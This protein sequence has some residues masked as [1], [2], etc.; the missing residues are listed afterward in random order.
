MSRQVH[1]FLSGFGSALTLSEE[2]HT[3]I[4]FCYE[5]KSI[6]G[7]TPEEALKGDWELVGKG[8]F[9]AIGQIDDE[10]IK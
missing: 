8:L 6:A 3:Q 7:I 2:D 1:D 5:G 10:W 9:G 4:E